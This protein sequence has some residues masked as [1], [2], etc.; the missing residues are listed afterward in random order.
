MNINLSG[1]HGC[2]PHLNLISE[3]F[4]M[5]PFKKGGHIVFHLLV[6]LFVGLSVSRPNDVHSISFDPFASNLPNLVQC[7]PLASKYFLVTRS[8][9]KVK[10]LVFAKLLSTQ[11]LKLITKV[12]LEQWLALES[13]CSLLIFRPCGLR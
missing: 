7:I 2:K 5:L 6:G 9:V 11:Y 12:N 1:H 4:F 13:R 8:K 3:N 10:L